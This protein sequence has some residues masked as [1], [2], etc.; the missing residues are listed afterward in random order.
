MI[1][2]SKYPRFQKLTI[3]DRTVFQEVTEKYPPY[4]DF[5]FTS[6]YCW[7][8]KNE[9]EFSVFHGNLIVRFN[10]Y[11]TGMPFYTF[12]GH[13]D[14]EQTIDILFELSQDH[15]FTSELKLIPE[16]A[17]TAQIKE[18][19]NVVEDRDNFDYIISLNEVRN[20]QGS[21]FHKKRNMVN[22]FLREYPLAEIKELNLKKSTTREAIEDLLQRWVISGNKNKSEA[23]NEFLAI[24]RLFSLV[25]SVQLESLGVF[26][27]GTLIGFAIDEVIHSQYAISHFEKADITYLGIYEFLKRGIACHLYEKDCVFFNL[28]CDLGIEG[29]RKAKELWHP[30][31][32]FKKY[33]ITP[34]ST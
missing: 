31:N 18:Q 33:T 34:K 27:E 28:E 32:Y 3:S 17:I 21:K 4:A 16:F 23:H 2:S 22:R 25:N 9:T 6:M 29:L 10:D 15:G 11:I 30:V 13:N 12:Y 14:V 19:Y 1:Q 26:Y 8:I 5:N 20:L 24:Q 7:D